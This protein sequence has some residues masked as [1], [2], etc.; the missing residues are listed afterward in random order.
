MASFRRLMCTTRL[1]SYMFTVR[2][3][4]IIRYNS[5][6]SNIALYSH[7]KYNNTYCMIEL[8]E[9]HYEVTAILIRM[10]YKES[11]PSW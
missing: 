1:V 8:Y 9:I 11:S 10:I 2:L 3:R 6:T 7:S 4:D 5:G